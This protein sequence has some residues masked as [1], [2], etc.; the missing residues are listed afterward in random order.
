MRLL[1]ILFSKR[2]QQ[3]YSRK[4]IINDNEINNKI[5]EIYINAINEYNKQKEQ[6]AKI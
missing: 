2:F 5:E 3:E 1:K 6:A 4:L